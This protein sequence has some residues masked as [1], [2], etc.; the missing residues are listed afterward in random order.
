[1]RKHT[2]AFLIGLITPL[3]IGFMTRA[4]FFEQ[5]FRS[6]IVSLAFG[7][8]FD[9]D[10]KIII[11]QIKSAPLYQYTIRKINYITLTA[12]SLMKQ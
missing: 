9:H 1:M 12:R 2:T 7:Q 5:N 4:N 8:L 3:V 6:K 10:H 11:L